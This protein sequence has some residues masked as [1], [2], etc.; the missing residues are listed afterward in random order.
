MVLNNWSRNIQDWL[1][2]RL[3]LACSLPAGAGN[4]LCPGCEQRLPQPCAAC[5]R[6]ARNFDHP[7][8]SGE[9][10]HC[11]QRPP[12][13]ARCIALYRYAPPV[14]HFIRALKFHR[15]LGVARL[16]GTRLAAR[17]AGEPLPDVIL[18][19]PLHRARLR[20]RGYN[21]ALEI[22]RPLARALGRPLDTR[23][24]E[25]V[26]ATT[27]QSDLSLAARRRN[28]RGAFAVQPASR[29]QDLHVAL[30]D[31]VMTSGSTA[32]AGVREVSVWVVAR[33]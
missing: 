18:P 29:V 20:E 4:D 14:D 19:V 27:A 31:D 9:C 15:D 28:V 12:A 13:Y 8:L 21:Q 25:R 32:Q 6:C 2:P 17:L 30:V 16:L 10:G 7:D 3:C 33:A 5:P 1:L 23:L 22:A 26:R 24:L 11:Q